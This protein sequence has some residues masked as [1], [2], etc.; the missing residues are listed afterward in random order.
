MLKTLVIAIHPSITTLASKRN[1][2]QAAL[3]VDLQFTN[4]IDCFDLPESPLVSTSELASPV[5]NIMRDREIEE[6]ENLLPQLLGASNPPVTPSTNHPATEWNGVPLSQGPA[7]NSSSSSSSSSSGCSAL[8]EV[9]QSI[10]T[11]LENTAAEHSRTREIIG[12]LHTV[13]DS[14]VSQIQGLRS[15][16]MEQGDE[17]RIL[18]ND[19]PNRTTIFNRSRI[20]QRRRTPTPSRQRFG[21]P[22]PP[23]KRRR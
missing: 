3:G 15:V 16:V 8:G 5:R 9:K 12:Q 1:K 18:K 22:L 11:L 17:I 10:S 2:H 21:H 13:I 14:Q 19:R 7:P 6:E 4:T 20:Q 23:A